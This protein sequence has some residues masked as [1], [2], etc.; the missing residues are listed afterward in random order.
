MADLDEYR[1][2]RNFDRTP[3]PSGSENSRA[4][5]RRFVIQKHAATNLH[6]DLRLEI[7]GVLKSWVVPKGPSLDPKEK[8]L[9][10]QVE[11]HPVDYLDFEGTIPSSE[12]GGG[13][14]LIWDFGNWEPLY[15][16]SVRLED[17]EIKFCLDGYKLQGGW[18]LVKTG[19]KAKGTKNHWLLFKE[20]DGNVRSDDDFDVT[21]AFP[22]SAVS[23][24]SIEEIADT[25]LSTERISFQ[26]T[27]TVSTSNSAPKQKK[28]K[29]I[30]AS[31]HP[32]AKRTSIP[33]TPK[34]ALPTATRF[35]PDDS[36]WIHEIKFDGYRMMC[37]IQKGVAQFI[38][39]NGNDWTSKLK[40]LA[41]EIEQLKVRNAIFDG[42]VVMMSVDGTTSFQDLQNR[43]GRGDDR[44]LRYFLFDLIY[45]NGHDIKG[46]QLEERKLLLSN[47]VSKKNDDSPL[48]F[49]DHI[50]GSGPVVFQQACKLGAEGIVSKRRDSKYFSGR[51][52]NWLKTKCLAS[53]EFVIGGFTDPAS[54]RTGFGALLIGF[55]TD[56]GSLTYAG[57]V[58]T[59]FTDQTLED[60][61][62]KLLAIESNHCPFDAGPEIEK[63][64]VHWV[65]PTYIAEIEFGGWTNDGVVR[66]PVYR[67]L[68]DDISSEEISVPSVDVA[69]LSRP[70]AARTADDQT[71]TVEQLLETPGLEKLKLTNA[72]RAVYEKAG[73]TKL[74]VATYYAQVAKWM[75]PHVVD[76]PL[77]LLRC[78]KGCGERCFFQK[79]A[80]LGLS[81]AVERIEVPTSD[82]T[83]SSLVIHDIV[84]LLALVQ[85]GVLEFHPWGAKADDATKPDRLVF[86]L[87]PD[88]NVAWRT[89]VDAAFEIQSRLSELG[90]TSFVKTSGG[91]GLHI[92]VPLRRR[93]SWETIHTFSQNIVNQMT[94]AAPTRFTNTSSKRARTGKI[95]IDFQRNVRGAT[96]VAA[97]STRANDTAAISVPITWQELNALPSADFFNLNNIYR[98]FNMQDTDPW[99]DMK[100]VSQSITKPMLARTN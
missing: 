32:K 58:G 17:G 28:S 52:Q 6:Y 19:R 78:P 14:V 73:I 2:K 68:R 24:R 64:K 74:G 70:Q 12:Y 20:Q 69:N 33:K 97:Y 25:S 35:P 83:A 1:R 91:K 55:Y 9:A 56:D 90:L 13:A 23:G 26:Q 54:S 10:I 8:R 51:T 49:S 48:F 5:E 30:S 81:D 72:D 15:D 41:R 96:S 36:R 67:G 4:G 66:F 43:I 77:S 93:N 11:D 29:P 21:N 47:L 53:D 46:L 16:D 79:R 62:E 44:E 22:N 3:E 27:Q 75:L 63:K 42:E 61:E 99:F 95:Y 38:S 57:R 39:R 45:W 85:F 71:P 40:T 98:R 18:M 50:E 89:V 37:R 59:G 82:G 31:R 60:L 86:D 84:G 80:P 7:D 76:R 100:N 92:F 34:P 94:A 88:V 87:D 65:E